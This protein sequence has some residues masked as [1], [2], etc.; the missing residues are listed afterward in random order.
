MEE[1]TVR[2]KAIEY[3]EKHPITEKEKNIAYKAFMEG[4]RLSE[5]ESKSTIVPD[6]YT[7]FDANERCGGPGSSSSSYKRC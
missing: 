4:Y 2:K 3:C 6:G 7:P 1:Y 5:K